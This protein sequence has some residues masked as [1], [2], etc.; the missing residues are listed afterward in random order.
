MKNVK[1]EAISSKI[2]NLRLAH[3]LLQKDV[4]EILNMSRQG[5]ARYEDSSC[6]PSVEALKKLADFYGVDIS[7]LVP[8][9]IIEDGISFAKDGSSNYSAR[10]VKDTV[11]VSEITDLINMYCVLNKDDR[12]ALF[13]Y[14]D[15]L[16]N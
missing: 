7:Y 8:N 14:I 12:K 15:K 5:Y 6:M 11:S 1:Y 3:N 4:A 2:K 10:I 16:N 13:N 9:I